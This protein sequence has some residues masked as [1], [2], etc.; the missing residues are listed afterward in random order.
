MAT[1]IGSATGATATATSGAEEVFASMGSDTF[2]KLLVAQMKYQNPMSPSD[3]TAM[4]G[5]IA[6]YA[7]VEALNKLQ[8]LQASGNSLA[9]AQ[10]ATSLIGQTVS[11]TDSSGT[12]LTGKVTAARFTDAG[13]VLVLDSGAELSV[14]AVAKVAV[15]GAADATSSTTAAATPATSSS[16]AAPAAAAAATAATGTPPTGTTT[17]STT[18]S[19]TDSGSTDQ[20]PSTT[21]P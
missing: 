19:S 11:A 7:Q 8:T 21:T 1:A 12:A 2:L 17:D 5:Q 20:G 9:E 18:D 15:A 3:P 16:P 10:I 4:M 14:S 6:T 13:P